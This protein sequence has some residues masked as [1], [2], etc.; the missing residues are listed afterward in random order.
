MTPPPNDR[1]RYRALNVQHL[2]KL[3]ARGPFDVDERLAMRAVAAVLPFRT[4]QYV[5]DTLIDWLSVP[6]DPIFRLTFPMPGMLAPADLG[7]MTELLRRE[8]PEREVRAAANEIR[9]RLSPHPG[10]Q[11]ELNPP[12]LD[13]QR[14]SGLQ[15]K[16]AE[17]L[18]VFPR[19][20]Q[21]CHAYCTYCFRWPQFIG[22]PELKIA[23]DE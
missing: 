8:A 5:V 14:L 15:H 13:G 18:L 12:V 16:Y 23:T 1:P 2:D 17:T 4:N 6:D 7:R 22:E 11:L 20:G 3:T 19:Q 9:G 21:T 10:G